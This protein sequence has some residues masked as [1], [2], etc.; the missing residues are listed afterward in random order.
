MFD[1]AV[2]R[3]SGEYGIMAYHSPFQGVTGALAGVVLVW[4][5]SCSMFVYILSSYSDDHLNVLMYV[6]IVC[7]TM[8]TPARLAQSV[9][10]VTLTVP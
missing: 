3:V 7:L 10:R 5:Y 6:Y 9:E 2:L 4:L 8:L 1:V